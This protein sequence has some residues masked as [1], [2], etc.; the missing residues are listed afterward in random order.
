MFIMF[1]AKRAQGNGEHIEEQMLTGIKHLPG[2]H[3]FKVLFKAEY[4]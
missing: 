2:V 3:G 1:L 4:Y